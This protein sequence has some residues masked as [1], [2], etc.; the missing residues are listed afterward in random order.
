MNWQEFT[1]LNVNDDPA[2]LYTISRMLKQ[3]GFKV[4][5]ALSGAEALKMLVRKPDIILLDVF[6]PGMDGFEV[7]RRIKKG[8]AFAHVPIIHVSATYRNT[9]AMVKG[10]NGGAESY[11]TLPLE[12][13]VLVATIRT[14]LRARQAEKLA[15]EAARLGDHFQRHQGRYR[16]ARSG[17]Q[18]A[19]RQ[20]S[21]RRASPTKRRRGKVEKLL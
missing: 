9:E 1:V 21:L 13:P 11:L 4:I 20:R 5:E 7:A 17:R 14:L 18:R 10:L 3:A 8:P 2:N 16:A 6:M 19:A 12:P 15:M